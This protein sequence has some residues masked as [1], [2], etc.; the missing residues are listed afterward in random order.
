MSD[1]FENLIN[2]TDENECQKVFGRWDYG[3]DYLKT[4]KMFVEDLQ[5][6]R[7]TLASGQAKRYTIPQFCYLI[8][9]LVSIRNGTRC[10]EA[11]EATILFVSSPKPLKIVQVLVRKRQDSFDRKVVLP[12]EITQEDLNIIRKDILSRKI[13]V[14]RSNTDRKADMENMKVMHKLICSIHKFVKKHYGFGSHATRYA[15]ISHL[16]DKKENIAV[17]SRISGHR[18]SNYIQ[19]YLSERTA[20]SILVNLFK[21]D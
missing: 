13:K 19:Y 3:L 17:I 10:Q 16:S 21:E 5:V 9:M 11:A 4:Y 2:E 14:Y 15:F 7:E 6:L 12:D 8:I 18:N 1:D 20:T